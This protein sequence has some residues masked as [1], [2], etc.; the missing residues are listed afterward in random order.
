M[1]AAITAAIVGFLVSSTS[2]TAAFVVTSENIKNGTIQTV[3]I[4]AKAKRALKGQ[5][6]LRGL[7]GAQG[8]QGVQ[9]PQGATGATGAQG[10]KG[11]T[12][13]TGPQGL[14]GLP[15]D[16]GPPATNLWAVVGSFG[17]LARGSGVDGVIRTGVGVYHVF[18]VQPLV[19]CAFVAT[20][21]STGVPGTA[22]VQGAGGA[23][24]R[25]SVFTFDPINLADR[26]FHLAVFC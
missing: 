25:V 21:E 20:V 19:D 16:P 22:T 23:P 15:G 26:G 17:G 7:A 1:R 11:D 6:G 8:P 5:R 14:Q 10:P 13:D 4:S 24:T 2:A 9:G 18:F 12:G 3:D